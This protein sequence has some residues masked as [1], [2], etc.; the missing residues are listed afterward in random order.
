MSK[1][2]PKPKTRKVIVR[3]RKPA[4]MPA[5]IP[6]PAKSRGVSEQA[7]GM[8]KQKRTR[9]MLTPAVFSAAAPP[10]G[11]LPKGKKIA[12]DS[13]CVPGVAAWAGAPGLGL[14]FAWNEGITFMGYNY[15]AVLAQIPEYRLISEVIATEM[16]RKWIKFKVSDVKPT[17]EVPVDGEEADGNET[18]NFVDGKNVGRL[19]T[20]EVA[21]QFP[22]T[23]KS[24]SDQDTDDTDPNAPDEADTAAAKL[25][26]AKQAKLK[27]LEKE[28]ERLNV[29]EIFRE[30]AEHDGFF[31]RA[32]IYIDTG[33]GDK[34][35][36]LMT[37]IG[38]G[39]ET[40]L[41]KYGVG[42]LK[43]L[44][45]VEPVWAYPSNYNANDPLRADWYRPERW[46]VMA[47]DLHRSRFL[48]FI[49]REV[50]D[51]MKP[52]FSFGGLSLTQMA[53]PYVDN[54]L[55]TRQSVNDLIQAFS[56]MVLSTDM[57]Q[58]L[59][60]GDATGLFARVDMFNDTRDN[61]GT[62]VLNKD[63][64]DMTNIAVPLGTLDHLQAQAQ[65]HIAAVSRI[66]LVKLTGISPTGLNASS[67]GE[68]RVFYDTIHAQQEKFFTPHLT[69]IFR[70]IQI[71]LWGAVD[72][73][74]SF[75]Y[76]PLW[77][78]DEAAMANVRKVEADTHKEYVDM[79]VV[80][81]L[82]VRK[83]IAGEKDSP[84]SGL[85]PNDL[86]E[87]PPP[88]QMPPGRGQ[89]GGEGDNTGGAELP[90]ATPGQPDTEA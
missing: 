67:E 24:P 80:D 40:T 28:F 33:D 71:N 18:P 13:A 81:P 8:A 21:P 10:P 56:T 3:R 29:R 2:K 32:H 16:T 35:D 49:G 31:G 43:A 51:M 30:V 59:E 70:L 1:K 82:E 22:P 46:F 36:E 25:A 76:E 42:F 62:F 37:P 86:P 88:P 74:I 58:V 45:V 23:I 65:E 52:Q 34:P 57:A 87:P 85:N 48:T 77:E 17:E 19:T 64:E 14:N 20:D 63:T 38:D 47:K 5:S 6:A 68:I 90:Q 12:Q 54:W 69:T 89:P 41:A 7:A 26:D 50:P 66:P 83:A 79:G 75:D 73:D 84:Y 11:V 60:G 9:Q 72:E 55:E 78:L 27:E 39:N 4:P 61:R 15:L 53:K 44:R